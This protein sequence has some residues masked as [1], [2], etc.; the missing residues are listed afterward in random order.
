MPKSDLPTGLIDHFV[1]GQA[2]I[3]TVNY[4]D[5][6]YETLTETA[7]VTREGLFSEVMQQLNAGRIASSAIAVT[8]PAA[9]AGCRSGPATMAVN[10]R[11]GRRVACVLDD[12]GT[13]LEIFDME[14]EDDEEEGDEGDEMETGEGDSA[15]V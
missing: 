8:R 10:G 3:A 13:S 1:A 4:A 9:L 2:H 15:E 7:S 12:S 6:A 5:L 11:V 14:G